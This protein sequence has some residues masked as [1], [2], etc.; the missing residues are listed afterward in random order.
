MAAKRPDS[1]VY[2]YVIKLVLL[3]GHEWPLPPPAVSLSLRAWVQEACLAAH[4]GTLCASLALQ[5]QPV[6]FSV[7]NVHC[8]V[9][10]EYTVH[11]TVCT[12][13]GGSG[14][15]TKRHQNVFCGMRAPQLVIRR[16]KVNIKP[17]IS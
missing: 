12:G 7:Y 13:G 8:N 4:E 2:L 3:P 1:L 11:R 9:Y 16:K 17:F 14:E 10:T 5:G 15:V 6:Q